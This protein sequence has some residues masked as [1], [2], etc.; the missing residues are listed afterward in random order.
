[1]EGIYS[2]SIIVPVH[3][4]AVYLRKCVDSIRSQ[5]L[6]NIEI[7]LVEN[8]S[9]DDSSTICDEYASVDSRI[10][11]LHLNE[12]GPSIARNAGIKYASAPYIGFVDSDDHIAP[13]MYKD[14]FD[15]AVKNRAE[16]VYCNF[17]NEYENG[18]VEF[19]YPESK[20]IYLRSGKDVLKDILCEKVSSTPCAKIFKKELFSSFLFPQGVFFE[21]HAV[22]YKWIALCDKV[23]W[24]DQTYYY[25]LQ[26]M[27]ST[28]HSINP[29]KRYHFFLAEYSR[30]SLVQN[31]SLFSKDERSGL[32]KLIVKNSLWHFK[33]FM[34]ISGYSYDK[35]M[36][37][38]M[39]GKFEKCLLLPKSD[40][41]KGDY[42]RLKKI[43]HFWPIYF[44]IHFCFKKR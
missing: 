17:C 6:Q 35:D 27:G 37:K 34:F 42:K 2:V 33:E 25:Y 44:V 43:V 1:M 26:R 16:V 5:T 32:T 29:T 12:A 28:C 3:N 7:I 4:S 41:R 39:K 11:V 10:K 15:A 38:D 24:I 9:T 22:V 18:N 13:T 19:F 40:I 14:M 31:Y 21:D 30:L 20:S 36:F 8:L 23:V